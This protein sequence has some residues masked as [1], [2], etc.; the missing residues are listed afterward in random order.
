MHGASYRRCKRSR[1]GD[2]MKEKDRHKNEK[3]EENVK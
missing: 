2:G 1:P 3:E